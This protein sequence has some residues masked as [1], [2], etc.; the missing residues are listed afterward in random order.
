[1]K[2]LLLVG[3]VAVLGLSACKKSYTCT[4]E[5]EVLGET[6]TSVAEYD[7]VNKETADAAEKACNDADTALEDAGS[8]T[9]AKK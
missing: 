6:S 5:V 2:K 4:C 8:C 1:M 7:K 9:W 3:A